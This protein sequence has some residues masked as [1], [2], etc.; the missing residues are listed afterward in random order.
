MYF[1]IFKLPQEYTYRG[2]N[3][4]TNNDDDNNK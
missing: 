3:N 4:N 1:L 2:L